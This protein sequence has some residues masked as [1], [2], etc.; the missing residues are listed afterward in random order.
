[1]GAV[2]GTTGE[3][4]TFEI[5]Y[6][7]CVASAS[8]R[9]LQWEPDWVSGEHTP[10]KEPE[11]MERESSPRC[12]A[13]QPTWVQR[14]LPP[15][16]AAPKLGLEETMELLSRGLGAGEEDVKLSALSTALKA[17]LGRSDLKKPSLPY[18]VVWNQ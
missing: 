17:K 5:P 16:V 2:F 3:D 4:D 14:G 13:L 1:M 10:M 12:V 7:K 15:R 18:H 9:S 8:P 11:C 6:G